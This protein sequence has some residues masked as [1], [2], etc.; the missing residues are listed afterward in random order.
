DGIVQDDPQATYVG[1]WTDSTFS[2][3]YY[4]EGYRHANTSTD[5]ATFEFEVTPGEYD[6]RFAYTAAEN[7]CRETSVL[8]EHADGETTKVVNQQQIPTL[9]GFVSLGAFTFNERATI[10]IFKQQ[11]IDGVVIV[12]AA[13]LVPL[14]KS[15][16]SEAVRQE[17]KKQLARHSELQTQLTTLKR[18]IDTLEKSLKERPQLL[19]VQDEAQI[20]DCPLHIR[21]V[22]QN[23]G[24]PVPRGV[25]QV[26][27]HGTAPQFPE[28]TS[29]RLELAQWIASAENPL[30]ARVYVNRVWSHLFGR[31]LVR[32]VDNFGVPGDRPTHPRLLDTLAIDFMEQGWSTK[33]LIRRLVLTRAYRLAVAPPHPADPENRLLSRATARRLEAEAL[34]DSL[35]LLSGELQFDLGGDTMRPGTKSEY[36]YQFDVGRRALYLPVFRNE[37]PALFATF[38]FPNP[39]LSTGQRSV[40]TLSTQA[41]YLLNNPFVEQRAAATATRLLDEFATTDERLEF[42]ALQTLS[43]PFSP[44]EQQLLRSYLDQERGSGASEPE[45]WARLTHSL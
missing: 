17:R 18:E 3:P 19:S 45:A 44:T 29:G 14:R 20:E 7:R 24:A 30:T 23:L 34:Y 42:L 13:M 6:V 40:S 5:R 36:G 22:V 21:G 11:G 10:S 43:R 27:L 37:L 16:E 38:D 26:A 2:K 25:L 8:I 28:A 35:L 15:D 4:G 9:E 39:N 1:N 41:L 32:S 12:D 33:Q 31:G